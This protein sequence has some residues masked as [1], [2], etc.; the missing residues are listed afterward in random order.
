MDKHTEYYHQYVIN[1]TLEH[2]LTPM[3]STGFPVVG[4][5][6]LP[7]ATVDSVHTADNIT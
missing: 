1:I 2:F 6:L 5:F 4:L 7:D 3:V